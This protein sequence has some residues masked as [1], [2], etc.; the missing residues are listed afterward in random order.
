[1]SPTVMGL[2]KAFG[3]SPPSEKTT[4]TAEA[5]A[6][7][8]TLLN[9]SRVGRQLE[10][11]HRWEESSTGLTFSH[12][13]AVASLRAGAYK[14]VVGATAAER[15]R[16]TV[17]DG[18]AYGSVAGTL[19]TF[20]P[21]SIAEMLAENFS[22]A[23]PITKMLEALAGRSAGLGTLLRN[24]RQAFQDAALAAWTAFLEGD[25]EAIDRFIVVHL[26]RRPDDRTRLA[27]QGRL[28]KALCTDDRTPEWAYDSS[29][30]YVAVSRHIRREIRAE[31]DAKVNEVERFREEGVD[32]VKVDPDVG[33]RLR[34]VL[35]GEL[36]LDDKHLWIDELLKDHYKNQEFPGAVLVARDEKPDIP[37]LSIR[38]NTRNLRSHTAQAVTRAGREGVIKQK[39]IDHPVEVNEHNDLVVPFDPK[40]DRKQPHN[41]V[42]QAQESD[43]LTLF[44]AQESERGQ[45]RAILEAIERAGLTLQEQQVLDL[46]MKK[47]HSYKQIGALLGRPTNQVGSVLSRARNKVAIE[48]LNAGIKTKRSVG[49]GH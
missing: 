9:A 40:E 48:L 18:S 45:V 36:G 44:A 13:R 12:H 46:R 26:Y 15:V 4:D 7:L 38:K 42:A 1:M 35:A 37:L 5:A 6:I 39:V 8:K 25:V 34:R 28:E 14:Q 10:P 19:D 49:L 47:H 17:V 29:G 27:V 31:E 43:W 22:S 3:D 11:S 2:V 41:M 21:T 32:R 24:R 23:Q 16:Y 30:F 20:K 33:L